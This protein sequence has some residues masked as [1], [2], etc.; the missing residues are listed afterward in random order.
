M[1]RLAWGALT[2]GAYW[3]FL[4]TPESTIWTLML[5]AALAIVS[6]TLLAITVNG[7]IAAWSNGVSRDTLRRALARIPAI[8]PAALIVVMA[9]WLAGS[10]TGWVSAHSGEISAWFIARLGW[11]D[12]SALFT[13]IEW[14][15][16]WIRWILTPMIALS[17]MAG[18]LR[19]GVSPLRLALATVWFL[20][21]VAAPWVYFAPWKPAG[22]PPTTVEPLFIAAKLAV[23]AIV[24]AIGAALMIREAART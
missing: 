4:N 23:A 10:V 17:L 5:S 22:L 6:L 16:W 18:A 24:M 1:K 12:V 9:W 7:A 8:V 11:S 2:G 15:G 19:R 14:A 20:L 21:L 3:A 13:G